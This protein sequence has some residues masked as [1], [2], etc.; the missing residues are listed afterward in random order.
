MPTIKQ[1]LFKALDNVGLKP[2]VHPPYQKIKYSLVNSYKTVKPLFAAKHRVVL[3]GWQDIPV[4][5]NNRNRFTF[6]LRLIGWL[7]K[8][9]VQNIYILDN[10]STYPPLLG[11]YENARQTVLYLGRNIGHTALW[12]SAYYE[13]FKHNYY[14]YTDPDV[15]PDENCPSDVIEMLWRNLKKHYWV[16]KIGVSLRIDDLPDHFESKTSTVEFEKRYFAR[17]LSDQIY[18]AA[19][20]TTFALYRPYTSYTN[21]GLR[22]AEP[23]QFR[24]LPW[25]LDYNNLSEEETYYVKNANVSSTLG[26]RF[27]NKAAAKPLLA[28]LLSSET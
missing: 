8:I 23:Y 9:G 3:K 20:D 12:D 15:V 13:L 11:F 7:E 16:E 6:P 5:I 21:S 26:Q 28:P 14:I 25:Y 10:Q 4:I 1:S 24:H 27:K 17:K 18:E 19:V 22:L 2:V